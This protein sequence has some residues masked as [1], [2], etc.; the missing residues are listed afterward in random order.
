MNAKKLLALW[1]LKWDP[2]S[3]EL[4]GDALLVTPA[5]EHFAW[6]VEQLAQE[7]GFA[8]ITGESGTGKSVALRI[9]AG[10]LSA[11]RDVTVG[12]LERPQSRAADFYRELGDLFAVKLHAAQPLGRLQGAARA[13]EGAHG[14]GPAPAG[15]P[16]RRGAGDEPRRPGRAADPLRVPTSMPRPS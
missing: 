14:L 3:P 16:G 5:I 13:L 15:A 7:G 12:V 9:V 2:F 4:P 11:L 10:R 1:G 6:R 8:L